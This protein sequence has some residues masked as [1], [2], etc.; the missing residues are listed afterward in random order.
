MVEEFGMGSLFV[1]AT[2]A[3]LLCGPSQQA[4][5]PAAPAPVIFAQ[6][7]DQ[8]SDTDSAAEAERRDTREQLRAVL[9]EMG[10]KLGVE[11]HQ[12]S[13][14]EFYFSGMLR[15]GLKNAD[16]FEIVVGVSAKKTISFRVYPHRAGG[17]IN[18]DKAKNATGLMRSL[19]QRTDEG[20]L[21]W[22]ADSTHDVFSGFTFTLE[23][24]FP[25]EAVK[26]VLRSIPNL[27]DYVGTTVSFLE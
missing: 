6:S 10:P 17:Y 7:S 2:Y 23:S 24:G 25:A 9:N 5:A 20:F 18:L 21:Y 19:L 1:L 26:I 8:S 27:D 16:S 4:L 12:S 22:G 13:K 15:Q 3:S 11:F 14:N